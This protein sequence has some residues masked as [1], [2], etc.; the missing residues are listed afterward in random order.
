MP[1]KALIRECVQ[2]EPRQHAIVPFLFA[3]AG[4]PIIHS[5]LKK[6]KKGDRRFS[7]SF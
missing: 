5:T 7:V 2:K 3:L 6:K 4:Q 1:K